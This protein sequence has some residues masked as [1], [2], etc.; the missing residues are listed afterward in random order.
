MDLIRR[1]ALG[2]L[3]NPE[4]AEAEEGETWPVCLAAFTADI[5]QLTAG[6]TVVGGIEIAVPV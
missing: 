3:I 5:M 2:S 4:I 1:E 6:G